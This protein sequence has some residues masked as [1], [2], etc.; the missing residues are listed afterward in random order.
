MSFFKHMIPG[1]RQAYKQKQINLTKDPGFYKTPQQTNVRDSNFVITPIIEKP[2]PQD[3]GFFKIPPLVA[4][5][6]QEGGTIER[7]DNTRVQKPIPGII[8]VNSEVRTYDNIPVRVS[9]HYPQQDKYYLGNPA[10]PMYSRDKNI[11]LNGIYPSV[12]GVELDVLAPE[13]IQKINGND[14]TYYVQGEDKNYYPVAGQQERPAFREAFKNPK[15]RVNKPN[16]F[17]TSEKI[18]KVKQV[19]ANW[20]K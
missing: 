8:P 17:N 3:R 14:T 2:I 9:K 7:T 4:S 19:I 10:R 12:Y 15:A 20:Q 1:F 18:D 11:K 6:Q 5:K 16:Y 13:Y